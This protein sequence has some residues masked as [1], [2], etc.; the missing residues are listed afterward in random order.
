LATLSDRRKSVE[1]TFLGG[2]GTVNYYL[3]DVTSRSEYYPYG[4]VL[5]GRS[6][7]DGGNYR[8]GF[9]G[10]EVD[11]EVKGGNN[12]VNYKYRMHDPRVGRFFAVDPL[13]IEYPELTPYQFS[14]NN[15][16]WYV[17]IEGLEGYPGSYNDQQ[18]MNAALK[19]GD[20]EAYKYWSE[21][22]NGELLSGRK[23]VHGVLAPVRGI[24]NISA[25][26]VANTANIPSLAA[27]EF[28][29]DGPLYENFQAYLWTVDGEGL[30]S[31][32]QVDGEMPQMEVV[33]EGGMAI[34]TELG[35]AKAIKGIAAGGKILLNKLDNSSKI[36]NETAGSQNISST[37]DELAGSVKDVNKQGGQQNCVNCAIAT[38]N[39]LAGRPSSALPA[40]PW[41][42]G[43]KYV[44]LDKPQP[45]SILEKT[46]GVKFNPIKLSDID[47]IV[48]NGQRG[49]L[50]GS[51]ADGT[52][53]VINFTKKNGVIN[54][55]DGQSGGAGSTEGFESVKILIT[56]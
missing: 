37:S 28:G 6:E 15:V 40:G 41:K 49:I 30:S 23:L 21:R 5:P 39:I 4:M 34:I 26:I 45:I 52:G 50:F 46:Y 13:Y 29:A 20:A 16:T 48:K 22:Y 47:N 24:Y 11:D 31:Y 27:P 1:N 12:S 43:N 33:A 10:Q 35:A 9:Q 36:V 38:D 42:V 2:E 56:N 3:A 51:R 55:I 17:E 7:S 44:Y 53:H 8:Y 54:Y 32:E 25:T 18:Q 19:R 14:S